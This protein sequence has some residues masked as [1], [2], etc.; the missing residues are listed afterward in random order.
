LHALLVHGSHTHCRLHVTLIWLHLVTHTRYTRVGFPGF[1]PAVYT[2]FA[3]P[4][5]QVA[6]IYGWL[7]PSHCPLPG[8]RM[9]LLIP[10]LLPVGSRLPPH[11]FWLVDSAFGS[12]YCLAARCLP[13]YLPDLHGLP[14]VTRLPTR[15][16]VTHPAVDHT[17]HVV[18]PRWLPLCVTGYLRCVL[19]PHRARLG[20]RCGLRVALQLP[21][22]G[23]H[24]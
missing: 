21:R 19:A 15:A 13:V 11:T 3:F 8:S 20:L 12:R 5:C 2:T 24:L 23:A 9:P 17:G 6:G 4:T 18:T 10:Q 1:L 16:A 22:Y 7:H 14:P